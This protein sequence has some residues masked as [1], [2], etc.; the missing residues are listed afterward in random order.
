MGAGKKCRKVQQQAI[1]IVCLGEK[2]QTETS[3]GTSGTS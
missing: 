1:I 3:Q 2:R